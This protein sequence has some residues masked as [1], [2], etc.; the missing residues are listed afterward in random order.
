MVIHARTGVGRTPLITG[1]R[2]RLFVQED[3]RTVPLARSFC[4][5]WLC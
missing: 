4:K 5:L 1:D 3:D 2:T